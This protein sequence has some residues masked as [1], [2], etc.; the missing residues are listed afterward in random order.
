MPTLFDSYT[1]SGLPLRN[2]A[3]MAPM[4]RARNPDAVPNDLT[5]QYYRQRAGAGLIV[6]EGVPVSEIANGN[7]YVPGLYTDAQVEGWTKVTQA[8][9]AEGGAIFAQLWHVGRAS[10]QNLL[11]GRKPHSS[12]A[13]TAQTKVFAYDLNGKPGFVPA[14]EPHAMTTEEVRETAFDFG[15]AAHRAI[16]AG[17]DGVEIHGAN[18]YLLEQFLNPLVNDRTDQYGA[19]NLDDRVRFV[20]EVVDSVVAATAAGK[21]GI[22]LSPW[23]R[24][25]DM[26]DYAQIEDTYLH[27][28]RKLAERELAYVHLMDQSNGQGRPEVDGQNAAF[29]AKV[30]EA[31]PKGAIIHAGAMTLESGNDLLQQGLVDLVGFGQPFI[32]N[33]DLVQ[34][35]QHGWPL[36]QPDRRT[37]YGGGSEGYTDY[38]AYQG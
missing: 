13:R 32:S 33:P 7:L 29:L 10:H 4:T 16:K 23:G 38:P 11:M 31:F 3:V 34:R 9:H 17:F 28:I 22:R 6:T 18:G 21:V 5:A 20:L 35:L 27:L 25:N 14:T 2:R 15:K 30:R 1:L 24:F 26:P 36:V 12:T 8:V 19:Q 37:Y